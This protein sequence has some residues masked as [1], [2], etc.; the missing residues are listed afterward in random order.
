MT[1]EP[2]SDPPSLQRAPNPSYVHPYWD[3]EVIVETANGSMH[4]SYHSTLASA[5]DEVQRHWL[6]SRDKYVSVSLMLMRNAHGQRSK[7]S[8]YR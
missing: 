3:Y 8:A 5:M 4:T 1:M 7:K 2:A 6:Q